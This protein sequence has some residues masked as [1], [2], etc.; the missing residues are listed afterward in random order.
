M[1][2][3]QKRSVIVEPKYFVLFYIFLSDKKYFCFLW[4]ISSKGRFCAKI[5]APPRTMKIVMHWK[6]STVPY[7]HTVTI[8]KAG[9]KHHSAKT[10]MIMYKHMLK[11]KVNNHRLLSNV[12][13]RIWTTNAL[14]SR[15]Y[16]VCRT[17]AIHNETK[18]RNNK[19][20]QDKKWWFNI[21]YGRVIRKCASYS[22]SVEWISWLQ[23]VKHFFCSCI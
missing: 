12:G 8:D 14:N 7:F 10:W 16:N 17:I 11:R 9:C 3:T 6:L 1:W 20:S 19:R 5:W 2:Q 22:A 13:C 23:H 21:V 18:Y 15:V 4:S